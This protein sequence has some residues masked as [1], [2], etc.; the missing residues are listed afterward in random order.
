MAGTGGSSGRTL[1]A[2]DARSCG[3]AS[4][5][6][7]AGLAKIHGSVGSDV[8]T[9]F[10]DFTSAASAVAVARLQRLADEGLEVAFE[11][12]DALGVDVA[13]PLTLD[14]LAELDAVAGV[15][16]VEGVGLRRPSLLR[17]TA[18]AHLV[19][20]V[21]EESGLAASWRERCYRAVWSE[22]VD[23]TD[24][25]VLVRLALGA[26]L[27]PAPVATALEDGAR[28]AA[29]RRRLGAHRRNGVGG[30]PTIL[31]ARTL[32]PGLLDED[33]LRALADL[34]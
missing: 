30:V 5:Q 11:G 23:I 10:H 13:L 29:I 27:D 21:A 3:A 12:F 2:L 24:P 26:G 9:L 14:T 25:I 6:P 19:G 17:P 16:D 28:L 22:D 34:G 8:L 7:C 32:V 4:P 18:R 20:E 31:T 1:Q 15:A 33:A